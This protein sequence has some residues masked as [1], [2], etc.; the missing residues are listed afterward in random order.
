MSAKTAASEGL[1]G[2]RRSASEMTHHTAASL[3]V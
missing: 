2:A 3:V 1:A